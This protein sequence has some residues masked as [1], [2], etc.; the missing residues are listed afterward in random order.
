M[1]YQS[2]KQIL[3]RFLLSAQS[4]TT[5]IKYVNTESNRN[6]KA[7]LYAHYQTHN[8]FPHFIITNFDS[9]YRHTAFNVI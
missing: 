5:K 7:R 1:L 2:I 4:S 3:S 8:A 9:A 6:R